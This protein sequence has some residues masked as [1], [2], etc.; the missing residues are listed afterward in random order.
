[1]QELVA[2]VGGEAP[3]EEGPSYKACRAKPK[4]NAFST[5]ALLGRSEAL[6]ALRE[7]G[8]LEP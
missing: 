4:Y 3:F 6:M 7:A 8:I 5:E 1:M 2:M